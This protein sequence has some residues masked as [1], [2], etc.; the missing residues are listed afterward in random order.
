MFPNTVDPS[1]IGCE[2][3]GCSFKREVPFHKELSS[4]PQIYVCHECKLVYVCKQ[5]LDNGEHAIHVD[6][7]KPI[8][9]RCMKLFREFKQEH[10]P[11]EIEQ[12]IPAF[13]R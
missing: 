7:I 2:S 6:S 3:N 5:C 11:E 10:F 13:S 4:Y 12:Y 8:S 9:K 1:Y